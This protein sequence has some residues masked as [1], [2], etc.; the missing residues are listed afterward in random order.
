MW[1]ALKRGVMPLQ[2]KANGLN[3][4]MHYI[5]RAMPSIF[6]C[7]PHHCAEGLH[8]NYLCPNTFY[9]RTNEGLAIANIYIYLYI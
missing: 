9:N 7:M 3:L 2:A 5:H 4:C 6:M 8:F 1:H